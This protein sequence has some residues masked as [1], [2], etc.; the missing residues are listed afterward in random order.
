[1]KSRHQLIAP[2]EHHKSKCSCSYILP[3]LTGVS[4]RRGI[5]HW[6]IH[7]KRGG[8]NSCLRDWLRSIQVEDNI[9]DA[10][11]SVR[12]GGMGKILYNPKTTNFVLDVLDGDLSCP[13][14]W[15]VVWKNHSNA[16]KCACLF[17][18]ERCWIM[19][20]PNLA[21]VVYYYTVCRLH[22]IHFCFAISDCQHFWFYFGSHE[23][24]VWA[25]LCKWETL[26]SISIS[27]KCN[28]Q[29]YSHSRIKISE[30]QMYTPGV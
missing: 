28:V 6:A 25:K 14:F 22:A 5:N 30:L 11:S 27:H 13:E 24:L 10:F 16:G 20:Y 9:I 4:I 12:P 8:V 17:F 7:V 19:R 1:M 3:T 23:A 21:Q 2:W 29:I 18:S 26:Q 15:T